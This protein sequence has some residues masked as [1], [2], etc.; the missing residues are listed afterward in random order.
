VALTAAGAVCADG[1]AGPIPA[2]AYEGARV[3][4]G[5][6]RPSDVE[7]GFVYGGSYIWEHALAS[8]NYFTAD[9]KNDLQP[10]EHGN[11]K[12]LLLE[13]NYLWRVK[14]DP[15]FYGGVGYGVAYSDC[16]TSVA[17]DPGSKTE[18]SGVA[19][20]VVGQELNNRGNFG[21]PCLFAEIRYRLF[22]RI[23]FDATDAGDI[24]GPSLQL[25]WK[26]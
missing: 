22:S 17:V 5:Y 4:V 24:D 23:D 25:G 8:A 9:I 13:A 12:I 2:S 11:A 10:G 18:F 1:G 16:S 15:G 20:V 7:S 6:I 14:A 21:K 19:N 3:Q 26:F